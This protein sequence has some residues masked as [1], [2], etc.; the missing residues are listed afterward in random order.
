MSKYFAIT[1]RLISNEKLYNAMLTCRRSNSHHKSENIVT[2]RLEEI[3]SA[4]EITMLTHDFSPLLD[5]S[6]SLIDVVWLINEL[7]RWCVSTVT[8]QEY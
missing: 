6:S 8:N 1:V 4:F 5:E 7:K 2:R 3:V